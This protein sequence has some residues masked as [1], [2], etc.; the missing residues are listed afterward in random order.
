M[1]YIIAEQGNLQV[2]IFSLLIIWIFNYHGHVHEDSPFFI[3][4]LWVWWEI[5]CQTE[6]S[7]FTCLYRNNQRQG[8]NYK[9]GGLLGIFLNRLICFHDAEV[10]RIS[11]MNLKQRERKMRFFNIIY[12]WKWEQMRLSRIEVLSCSNGILRWHLSVRLA[13]GHV[14][15]GSWFSRLILKLVRSVWL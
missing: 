13:L 15:A 7:T 4:Q 9:E 12:A 8:K 5:K 6:S 10:W 14:C 1:N 11:W 3:M 2:S